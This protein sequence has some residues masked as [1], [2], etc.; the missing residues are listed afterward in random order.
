MA[1]EHSSKVMQQ[2]FV[3]DYL[4]N[5][6]HFCITKRE[7]AIREEAESESSAHF[8]PLNVQHALGEMWTE[9]IKVV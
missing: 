1:L 3:I 4:Q 9:L 6:R 2:R 8:L 5:S 7:K